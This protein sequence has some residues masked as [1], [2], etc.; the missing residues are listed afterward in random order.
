MYG[1][2]TGLLPFLLL[3]GFW[4]FLMRNFQAGGPRNQVLAEL[5]RIRQELEEIREELKRQRF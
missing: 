3:L 1:I 4:L 2:V 5:E